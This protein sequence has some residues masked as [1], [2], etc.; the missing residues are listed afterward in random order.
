MAVRV[1]SMYDPLD[2][3]DAWLQWEEH[4]LWRKLGD[5]GRLLAL[6]ALLCPEPC[7]GA[8]AS[9]SWL[10]WYLPAIVRVRL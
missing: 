1:V 7:R 2:W 5:D 8:A 6:R 4:C 3:L 10:C 9:F